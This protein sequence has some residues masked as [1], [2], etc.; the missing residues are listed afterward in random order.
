M[1]KNGW[2]DWGKERPDADVAILLVFM[3]DERVD[4]EGTELTLAYMDG[5]GVLHYALP[6][7]GEDE[8]PTYYRPLAWQY[9]PTYT[10]V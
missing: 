2:I 5:G 3:G 6:V 9:P 4:T 1:S 8:M 7:D 10:G